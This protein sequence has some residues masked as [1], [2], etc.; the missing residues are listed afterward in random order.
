MTDAS[1]AS[2]G[3]TPSST[4]PTAG[5]WDSPHV[6]I[7]KRRP[8]ELDIAADGILRPVTAPAKFRRVRRIASPR[9]LALAATCALLATTAWL[10]SGCAPAGAREDSVYFGDTSPPEGQVFTFNNGAEPEHLDPAVMSGQPDGRIAR[11]VFEGL[12]T[13]DPVTLDPRPGQAARWDVSDD[14]LTY[15]FHLRPGL[16]WADGTPLTAHDF[17][18]S[19]RR[20]LSPATG[21]RYASFLFA[22]RNGEEFN[23][24]D[25][26]DSTQLG[27]A[28]PD[29]TTF[30]VTLNQPTPYFLELTT[31]YTT[32]PTPR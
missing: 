16:V 15:T 19:W 6:V 27:L 8:I 3:G 29:D 2:P 11:L 18:W 26:A 10:A 5:P 31:F 13:A 22:V 21:S 7:V 23:S 17:V 28:A 32:L 30:V 1:R 20:A 25:L 4:T 9:A 14:G 12:C 24:G